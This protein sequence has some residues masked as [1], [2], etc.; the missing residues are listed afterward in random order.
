MAEIQ[1]Y[2]ILATKE[3]V[4]FPSSSVPLTVNST[5]NVLAIEASLAADGVILLVPVKDNKHPREAKLGDL[6]EVGTLCK[7]EQARGSKEDGYQIIVGGL[8]R[9]DIIAASDEEDFVQ[10]GTA[11]IEAIE[12]ID[13]EARK[14]LLENAKKLALDI[15]KLSRGSGVKRLTE[16]IQGLDDEDLLV[17]TCAA[18]LDLS[19]EDRLELLRL[20]SIKQR[21]LKTIELLQVKK[22]SMTVQMEIN[23]KLSSQMDKKQREVILREQ[24]HAIREELGELD[25]GGVNKPEYLERI[26]ASDM[27]DSVK[28]VA[29]DEAKRLESMPSMSPEGPS[30]RNY[31]DLMLELPWTHKESTDIDIR[32]ARD[33]LNADHYGLD[34]VKDRIIQHLAVMQLNRGLKGSILLLVGPPGVGKT[35][36]GKSIAKAMHREFVRVSLGGVRDEADIRGHRRTYLGSMPG[37]LI[38]GIKRAGTTNPVFLLDEIDKLGR[39]WSGDPAGALLEVLDPEQN[40]HFEDH[41]LDVPYDLSQVMF[42]ATANSLEGIPGPLRDRLEIIQ[43]SGYTSAE[44][45][46]IAKQHL[47]PSERSHHGLKESNVSIHDEAL[48][49]LITHYTREAGVRDLKR[50]LA[51]ICR[52]LT[53]QVLLAESGKSFVIRTKDL[54]EILGPEPFRMEMA[55]AVLPPGVVTGLAWTPMGGDILFIE[56]KQMRGKGKLTITGQLGEVMKESLHIAMSHIRYH[57][58][59]INPRFDYENRDIHVHVPSGAIPKDGPSAGI[60]MLT[61]LASLISGKAVS[62]EL[63]MSGEITLR[64]AVMP[65]GGV[66]EKVIAAQNAGIKRIILA[67]RNKKD[68]VDV[69]QDVRDQLEFHFVDTVEQVLQLALEIEIDGTKQKQLFHEEPGLPGTREEH[70]PN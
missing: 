1:R 32:H 57:L 7:I 59:E 20:R 17:H 49:R 29:R 30:I 58:S 64:G 19:F 33:V 54:E 6:F 34:K 60:T 47:W 56:A 43:L 35:S 46:H 45:L 51:A 40:Q 27:P 66:K 5:R 2:P 69:P 21:L 63:A 10:A 52:H 61:A 38:Q 37:R 28:A 62:P 16:L 50:K 25:S 11:R 18:H 67:T 8:F 4:V 68:L 39:G 24:L 26:E 48:L 3:L 36:L 31:L 55:E 53:E 44:K 70:F 15:L 65:V 41:Y 12:D 22:N 42:I 9:C 13:R 23:R 14:T